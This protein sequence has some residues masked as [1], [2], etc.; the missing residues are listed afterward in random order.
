M[1][2]AWYNM[3]LSAVCEIKKTV[4]SVE[5]VKC[6]FK[7]QTLKQPKLAQFD[8]VLYKWFTVMHSGGILMT[9]SMIIEIAN[10][11]FDEM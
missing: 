6:L 8:R 11:F 2:V 5:R 7:L 9:E 4:A 10:S 3:G 1:V